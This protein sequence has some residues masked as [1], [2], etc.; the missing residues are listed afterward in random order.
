[1][2]EIWKDVVGYEGRYEVSSLGRVRS[3][4]REVRNTASSTRFLPCIIIAPNRH[5]GGYFTVKLSLDRVK[6]HH[7][8]HRLVALAFIGPAPH[9]HEVLHGDGNKT[10]NA[11]PNLSWGT[12]KE[13]FIDRAR[14]GELLLGETH[15]N[16]KLTDAKV[17]A[18]LSDRRSVNEIA[19][20]Y[21]VTRS[22]IS[23]I[24]TRKT[25]RHLG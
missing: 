24:K 17:L 23:M 6:R 25:W 21:G 5:P 3:V 1:M 13:N 18:I 2:E 12:R 11:L 8:I 10:N 15:P 22:N 19:K 16:A 9:K 4:A 20:D 14:L 7:Y